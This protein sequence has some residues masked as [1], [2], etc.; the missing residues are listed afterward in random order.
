MKTFKLIY[1]FVLFLTFVGASSYK[2]ITNI[3]VETGAIKCRGS[4]SFSKKDKNQIGT[5]F[6]GEL[7]E[8]LAFDTNK[9][10]GVGIKLKVTQGKNKDTL[11][12]VYMH[13]NPK[14]RLVKLLDAKGNEVKVPESEFFNIIEMAQT[15]QKKLKKAT[16][17]RIEEDTPVVIDKS[18]DSITTNILSG[19]Y[20]IDETKDR[21]GALVPIIK[22]YQNS[23]GT[24]HK[25]TLWIPRE[26]ITET[27]VKQLGSLKDK[28]NAPEK[29]C[30]FLDNSNSE[31]QTINEKSLKELNWHEG[32]ETLT[33]TPLRENSDLENLSKCFYNLKKD[34]K[35]ILKP[36][37]EPDDINALYTN[38]YKKLNPI[39]QKFFALTMTSQGEAGILT[40][41]DQI[42]DMIA[43]M[44]VIDNRMNN[45][46][47]RYKLNHKINE[48]DIVLQNKQFSM[49]NKND[50][51]WTRMLTLSSHRHIPRAIRSYIKFTDP[52]TKFDPKDIEKV[53]HY[54]ASYVNPSWSKDSEIIDIK[55]NGVK[56]KG[57]NLRVGGKRQLVQHYFYKDIRWSFSQNQWRPKE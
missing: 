32:C 41:E 12:W 25:S 28:T 17:I 16:H 2:K 18:D 35:K 44:K 48:L 20:K 19:V 3:Q 1:F 45:A 56:P 34:I 31:P 43:V 13:K 5:L 4:S 50:P 55:I 15:F 57:D 53:M 9:K 22:T 39:E 46:N 21:G 47:S 33:K 54:H 14:K 7:G 51:Q 26:K 37:I 29:D 11:G 40:K 30:E 49:Y 52:N 10:Y 23:D 38:M 6:K 42:E 24:I 8:V 36:N 27:I